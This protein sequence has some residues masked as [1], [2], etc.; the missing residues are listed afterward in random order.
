[1]LRAWF[2]PGPPRPAWGRA[3]FVR[4]VALCLLVSFVDLALQAPGLIGRGGIL[5]VERFFPAAARALGEGATRVLPTLAWLDPTE[6]GVVRLAW[7]GAAAAAAALAGILQAP[8]LVAAWALYLSVS[9]AFQDFTSFQWDLLLLQAALVAA[10]AAPWVLLSRPATD[11]APAPA[12]GFWVRLVLAQLMLQAG[13]VKLAS[14][15]PLWRDL[16]AL[17]VHYE[18]QPLPSWIGWWAHQLPGVAQRASCLAMF[19]IE[20]GAPFMLFGPPRMR[21]AGALAILLLMALIALTGSYGVFNLLTALLCAPVL[22]PVPDA[23]PPGPAGPAET[24]LKPLLLAPLLA[25]SV[26]MTFQQLRPMLPAPAG[27]ASSWAARGLDA[28]EET[29]AP[30][31]TFNTYGLF[32]VMTRERPEL[33]LEA[34]LDGRTWVPYVLPAKPGDP[35]RA[36]RFAAPWMPRLDWQLWFAALAGLER[37]RWFPGLATRLLVADPA[38]LALFEAVPFEGR[39][40]RFVRARLWRYRF[41]DRATRAATGAWW[42]REPRGLYLPP[43]SLRPAPAP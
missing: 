13:W 25:G 3:L 24:R 29:L 22:D 6:A 9:L 40:P 35:A 28:L 20:L 21:R 27:L 17:T 23:A 34:S 33:E 18:T 36:P 7:I 26:L 8:M 41:T 10:F 11:P 19:A 1:M 42:T 16:S 32:A 15:D 38:V 12:A 39:P 30:L 5:P 31:R 43:A 4:G 2:L 14:G 37:T